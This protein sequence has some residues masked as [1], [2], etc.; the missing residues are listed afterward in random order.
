M[1]VVGSYGE[2]SLQSAILD[3]TPPKLLRLAG[4]HVL[5]APAE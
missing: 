5:V 1:I 4:R 2:L 3:S